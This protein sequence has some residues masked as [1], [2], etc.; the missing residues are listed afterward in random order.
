[1]SAHAGC[2]TYNMLTSMAQRSVRIWTMSDREKLGRRHPLQ[3]YQPEQYW[4]ILRH[5]QLLSSNS[6]FCCRSIK[7]VAY[8]KSSAKQSTLSFLILFFYNIFSLIKL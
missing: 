7:N 1:M 4:D 6:K 3:N 5:K 8:S 2:R